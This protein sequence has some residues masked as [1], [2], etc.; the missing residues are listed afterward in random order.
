MSVLRNCWTCKHMGVEDGVEICTSPRIDDP[1][2]HDW[3]NFSHGRKDNGSQTCDR[4]ADGC[5]A[6]EARSSLDPLG[7]AVKLLVQASLPRA[8]GVDI[9]ALPMEL[10]IAYIAG[11]V[12]GLRDVGFWKDWLG[13]EG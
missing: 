5:P 8:F 9:G 12:N 3:I 1:D 7:E 11:R 13:E 10:K 4:G 6:W 2:V